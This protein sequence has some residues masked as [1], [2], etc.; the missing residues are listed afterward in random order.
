M[1][2]EEGKHELKAIFNDYNYRLTKSKFLLLALKKGSPDY[3]CSV[4]YLIRAF[5]ENNRPNE[6]AKT[7]SKLSVLLSIIAMTISIVA[8][9]LQIL[10]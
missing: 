4:G 5:N 1:L 3:N 6:E 10:S 9:V 2:S 8:A 7:Q